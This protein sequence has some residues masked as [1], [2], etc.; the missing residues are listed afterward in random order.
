MGRYCSTCATVFLMITIITWEV[1]SKFCVILGKLLKCGPVAG[2]ALND[3]R[4]T[5]LIFFSRGHADWGMHRQ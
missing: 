5:C 1:A 4:R 2:N 3:R